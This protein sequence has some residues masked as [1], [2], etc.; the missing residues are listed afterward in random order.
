MN[1]GG[2]KSFLGED[3]HRRGVGLKEVCSRF[4][5]EVGSGFIFLKGDAFFSC[6]VEVVG[7]LFR[8]V[9]EVAGAASSVFEDGEG[10]LFEKIAGEEVAGKGLV[11]EGVAGD[12][13]GVEVKEFGEG[14]VE[15]LV[16]GSGVDLSIRKGEGEVRAVPFREAG[17]EDELGGG[18]DV[19]AGLGGLAG[20]V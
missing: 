8:G 5:P 2:S 1:V 20:I 15:G 7:E 3:P 11:L 19:P 4:L 18:A 10:G 12:G 6:V 17:E 9:G 14:D 16:K 13:G